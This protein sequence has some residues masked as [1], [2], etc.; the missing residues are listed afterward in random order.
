M[1]WNAADDMLVF[2]SDGDADLVC[3]V[4][5]VVVVV[6]T[7][8][9]A[10]L[11]CVIVAATDSAADLVI[12]L[13]LLTVLL[14]LLF[15]SLLMLITVMA[16][17]V[18]VVSPLRL[19]AYTACFMVNMKWLRFDTNFSSMWNIWDIRWDVISYKLS[20]VSDNMPVK[21]AVYHVS[22]SKLYQI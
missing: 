6:A 5:V 13:L 7:D 22:L 21:R 14:L 2:V 9:T 12:L 17:V 11:I 15:V 4:V 8:G 18:L 1:G 3:V 20:N 19:A 10:D 16:V